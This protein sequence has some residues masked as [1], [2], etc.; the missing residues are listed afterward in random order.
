MEAR[1]RASRVARLW[2]P[3]IYIR[4]SHHF[5]VHPVLGNEENPLELVR[6]PSKGRGK[7][8]SRFDV[9]AC[10]DAAEDVLDVLEGEV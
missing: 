3:I 9:A 7:S 1:Y 8:V 6:P 5:W 4:G 2:P 10:V